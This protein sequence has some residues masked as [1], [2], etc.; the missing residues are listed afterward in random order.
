MNKK[1]IIK[2]HFF[3][4]LSAKISFFAAEKEVKNLPIEQSFTRLF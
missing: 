3:L 4:P 1:N 2:N